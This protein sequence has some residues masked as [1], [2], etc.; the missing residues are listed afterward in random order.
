M[1][2]KIAGFVLFIIGIYLMYLDEKYYQLKDDGHIVLGGLTL[3]SF[4]VAM[5][6]KILK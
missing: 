3:I 1:L 5:M 6:L 2:V 4:G